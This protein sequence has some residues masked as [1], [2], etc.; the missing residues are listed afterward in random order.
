MNFD[1]NIA[2][3]TREELLDLFDL[4][5]TFD[6]NVFELKESQLRNSILNNRQ[7]SEETQMNT[8]KFIV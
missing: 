7:I 3:Y 8:I 6:A 2:N 5:P 1:L 4:P